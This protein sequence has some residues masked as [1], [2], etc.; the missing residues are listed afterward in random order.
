MSIDDEF[1]HLD[2]S[3]IAV[4][5]EQEVKLPSLYRV[6]MINDDFTSMEFV[7]M[8]LETVFGKSIESASK[9]MMEVHQKGVG[10]AGVYTKEVAETKINVVHALA[11][12][13]EFPL[14]CKLEKE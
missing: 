7:V 3:G 11:R 12:E 10:V 5:E 13:N 8:I 2:D 4:E 9:I 6:L 1:E 14:K